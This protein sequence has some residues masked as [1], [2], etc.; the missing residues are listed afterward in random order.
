MQGFQHLPFLPDLDDVLL[1]RRLVQV[2]PRGQPSATNHV[3]R[4]RHLPSRRWSRALRTHHPGVLAVVVGDGDLGNATPRSWQV[5]P[6]PNGVQDEAHAGLAA[7]PLLPLAVGPPGVLVE[8]VVEVIGDVRARLSPGLVLQLVEVELVRGNAVD[9]PDGLELVDAELARLLAE[10]VVGD[11]AAGQQTPALDV[12]AAAVVRGCVGL[13]VVD[14]DV[15]V[16]L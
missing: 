14:D 1:R 11:A 5:V 6:R 8:A 3:D 9:G 2:P 13:D 12:Q 15:D 16:V 10:L 4:P 7:H